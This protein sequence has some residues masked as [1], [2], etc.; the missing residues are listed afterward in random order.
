MS[1]YQKGQFAIGSKLNKLLMV[2]DGKYR[3]ISD[4][5]KLDILKRKLMTLQ[6]H[7]GDKYEKEHIK[8]VPGLRKIPLSNDMSRFALVYLL[9]FFQ[10]NQALTYFEKESNWISLKNGSMQSQEQF[11]WLIAGTHHNV[12][13]LTINSCLHSI[14]I[15]VHFATLHTDPI[16]QSVAG[17]TTDPVIAS[18][19]PSRP[20]SF[21]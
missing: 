14:L 18:W 5:C 8:M 4:V 21:V 7:D 13:T 11:Y 20:R 15:I 2:K 6:C 9:A 17:P 10:V 19:I 12:F 1:I 16:A 3:F